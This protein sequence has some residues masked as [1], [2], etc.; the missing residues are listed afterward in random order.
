M[1]DEPIFEVRTADGDYKIW[2]DGRTV[3]FPPGV[4]VNRI[5]GVMREREA[6]LRYP[7]GAPG[8]L[9]VGAN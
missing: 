7:A 2:S 1:S 3:G 8:T 6:A 5:P 9:A 4:V